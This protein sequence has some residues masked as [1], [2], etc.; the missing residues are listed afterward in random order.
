M[1]IDKII[2]INAEREYIRCG[3]FE[4]EQIPGRYHAFIDLCRPGE[5]PIRL[6]SFGRKYKKAETALKR[7]EKIITGLTSVSTRAIIATELSNYKPQRVA[8]V[9]TSSR[10]HYDFAAI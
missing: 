8:K 2:I 6:V 5:A 4:D 10:E 3:Y 9:V 1:T 7:A